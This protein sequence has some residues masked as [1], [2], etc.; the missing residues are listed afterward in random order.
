MGDVFSAASVEIGR[1]Y[2][3]HREY[4]TGEGDPKIEGKKPWG[5]KRATNI[6][7]RLCQLLRALVEAVRSFLKERDPR[8]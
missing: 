6:V 3:R 7:G 4:I 1:V 5:P 8:D 2:C